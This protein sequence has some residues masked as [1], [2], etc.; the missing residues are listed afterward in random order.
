MYFGKSP[1]SYVSFTNIFFQFV[2]NLLLK[3]F[4]ENKF[5]ILMKTL[6]FCCA[7][8]CLILCHSM[9][10]RPGFPRL[11]GKESTCNAGDEGKLGSIPG[12]GRSPGGGHDNPLQYSCLENP[13]DREA[14]QTTVH[15]SQGVGHKGR[16]LACMHTNTEQDEKAKIYET[17]RWTTQVSRCPVCYLE[18][19]REITPQRMKRQSQIENNTQLWMWLVMEIKS[20]AVKNNIA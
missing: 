16:K 13:M 12:S 7:Q 20:H 4:L 15:R 18:N 19:S 9:Y 17:E 3:S 6:L 8:T 11:S 5:L 14:W 1:L 2:S 10:C